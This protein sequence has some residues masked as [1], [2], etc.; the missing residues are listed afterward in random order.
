MG[1]LRPLVVGGVL[2]TCAGWVVG[3]F[4][5][6]APAVGAKDVAVH[7][8]ELWSGWWA[9]LFAVPLLLAPFVPFER[10]W[11]SWA[12]LA[13]VP[14]FVATVLAETLAP[15]TVVPH[16]PIGYV[17][18]ADTLGQALSLC[19]ALI[20]IMGLVAAWRRSPDWDEPR[21]WTAE[22]VDEVRGTRTE[23]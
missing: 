13:P 6:F 8:H 4:D 12:W 18:R 23:V 17:V 2:L 5:K 9:V 11:L 7:P 20:A 21:R 15:R 10:R 22:D 14:A 19:G 16:V 1:G 3:W